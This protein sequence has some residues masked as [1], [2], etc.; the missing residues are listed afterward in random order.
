MN[1]F[2][3][4]IVFREGN[5]SLDKISERLKKIGEVRSAVTAQTDSGFVHHRSLDRAWCRRRCS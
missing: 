1:R 4:T 2:L 3:V 5:I